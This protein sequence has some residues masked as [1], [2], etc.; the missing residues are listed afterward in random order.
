MV[1]PSLGEHSITVA[2]E[3]ILWS[4]RAQFDHD[5]GIT[6][7]KDE[8]VSLGLRGLERSHNYPRVGGRFSA[9]EGRV[10]RAIG[11]IPA[12]GND[13]VI[14]L[15]R[16]LPLPVVRIVWSCRCE[17]GLMITVAGTSWQSWW[18]KRRIHAAV[19]ACQRSR[20]MR[21]ALLLSPPP[22]CGASTWPMP[23]PRHVSHSP[24]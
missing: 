6:M 23:R 13:M 21:G 24:E 15:W 10:R 20:S 8:A 14:F 9:P 12:L 19:W 1:L 16:I 11:G 5:V 22:R 2:R 18:R 17:T 4:H 3:R 7:A